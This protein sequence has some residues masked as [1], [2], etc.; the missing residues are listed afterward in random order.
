[1]DDKLIS[2][3]T[4]VGGAGHCDRRPKR[5][6]CIFPRPTVRFDLEGR[7]VVAVWSWLGV[8]VVDVPNGVKIK[9]MPTMRLVP[10]SY[11]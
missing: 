5:P 1:V 10:I 3:K 2:I 9:V 6:N 7:R 11:N 4:G 8:G